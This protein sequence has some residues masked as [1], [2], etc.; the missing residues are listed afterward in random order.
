MLFIIL[1]KITKKTIKI[2]TP[3]GHEKFLVGSDSLI[4]WEGIPETDTCIIDYTTDN[5]FSWKTLTNKAFGNKYLWS[6]IPKPESDFCKVA[7]KQVITSDSSVNE[8][9]KLL[10]IFSE[11][12]SVVNKAKWSPDDSKIASASWDGSICV[13][14]P[15]NAQMLFQVRGKN[16]EVL[17]I[18]WSPD[19][20]KLATVNSRD[21]VYIYDADNGNKLYTIKNLSIYN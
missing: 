3:N 9:Y 18:E 8:S 13:W 1:I 16:D 6:N 19:G 17:D 21:N 20:T 2:I 10:S 11:H 12:K 4:T 14:D 5:G 15:N 7:V